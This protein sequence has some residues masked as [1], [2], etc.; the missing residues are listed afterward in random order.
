[1]AESNKSWVVRR[2]RLKFSYEALYREAAGFFDLPPTAVWILYTLMDA[3]GDIAQQDLGEQWG[4]PKQTINSTVKKL[5]RDGYV[6]LAAIPGTR[7][8]KSIRLT[9]RG[10][11]LAGRTARL[12][13]EAE[14]R[15][16]AH[17]SAEERELYLSLSQKFYNALAEESRS[18]RS[19]QEVRTDG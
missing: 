15:A 12:L 19:R 17:L 11:A 5:C 16:A 10:G 13:A 1:M 18:I 2:N 4:F 6:T 9:A 3:D 14:E 8:R 7:N